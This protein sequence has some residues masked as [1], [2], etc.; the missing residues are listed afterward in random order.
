MQTIVCKIICD[1]FMIHY[2]DLG[3]HKIYRRYYKTSPW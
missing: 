2:K 3:L 1:F